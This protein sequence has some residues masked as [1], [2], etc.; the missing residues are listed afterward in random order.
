M[1]KNVLV[2][3]SSSFLTGGGG[4]NFEKHI[5]AVFA[6]ALIIDG[7][8]PISDM[9]V[10]K[11]DFQAKNLGWGTDDLLVTAPETVGGAK[12]LCQMKHSLSATKSDSEFQSVIAEAWKDF[13]NPQFNKNTDRIALITGFI[14]KD[15]IRALREIHAEAIGNTDAQLF[16]NRIALANY[17]SDSTRAVFEA[18]KYAIKKASHDQEPTSE[19]LWGFWRCFVFAIFDL[20]YKDSVNRVLVKSLIKCKTAQDATFVWNSICEACSYWN[21]DGATVCRD[22]IPEEI[23][24][25]FGYTTFSNEQVNLTMQMLP[26]KMWSIVAL[27]GSWDENNEADCNSIAQIADISY[28]EFQ[29]ECHNLHLKYPDVLDLKNG[30]WK[31]ND[32]RQV[33]SIVSGFYFDDVIKRAFETAKR[34]TKEKNRQFD[35]DGNYSLL[36]PSNGRFTNSERFRKGLIEGLC[37]LANS[38]SLTNCSDNLLRTESHSLI[39]NIFSDAD[40]LRLSSLSALILPIAEMN[41]S[42]YLNCLE[43]FVFS[44]P[45]EIEKLFPTHEDSP[46]GNPNWISNILFSLERLAWDENYLVQSIRCLGALESLNYE[47]TNWVNAPINTIVNILLPFMP[48]TFASIDKQKNA[49]Q[50]LRVDNR[51]V[52][53]TVVLKLLPDTSS[54]VVTGTSKPKYIAMPATENCEF[55]QQQRF[56]LFQYYTQQAL[57]IAGTNATKLLPLIK[58]T[59]YMS[60]QEIMD[61]LERICTSCGLWSDNEKCS[62]WIELEDL[63]YRGVHEN[64]E[65]SVDSA[66]YTRLCDTITAVTPRSALYRYK[67]LYVSR[68]Y[69][70]SLGENRWDKL[71]EERQSA[72]EEIYRSFGFSGAVEFGF[73]VNAL[74]EIG[75][76]IGKVLSAQEINDVIP[77]FLSESV[78]AFYSYLIR[79]FLDENGVSA[80]KALNLSAYKKSDIVRILCLAPFTQAL[81]E[82][83]PEFLGEEVSLYWSSVDIPSFYMRHA[84][85][86]ISLVAKTLI[87]HQRASVAVE[88]FADSIHKR[89]HAADL[90]IEALVQ[91]ASEKGV[92]S[93]QYE[94]QQLILYLQ[95]LDHP[96]IDTLSDVEFLYL[97]WLDESSEAKPKAIKYRLA[98]EPPY[99]CNIIELAYKRRN[100]PSKPKGLPEGMAKRLFEIT[101]RYDVIPGT[102]WTG[103]FHS[104]IFDEWIAKVKAWA[105]END[106][107]EVS[108]QLIGNG[109]SYAKFDEN[110][111]LASSIMTV[112]NA[113]DNDEIRNGYRFG[114]MNQRGI[115]WLD[116]EGREERALA[117][118]FEIRADSI[119]KLGYSR[120]A[121][122]LRSISEQYIKEAEDNAKLEFEDE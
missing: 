99:F 88:L 17:H 101:Y 119:E 96:D 12:L 116:P 18:V 6:L 46:I 21:Q 27:I 25:L 47:K 33:L 42:V 14:A 113:R 28:R 53:W 107:F 62:F 70:L 87:E 104:D 1:A 4:M 45:T 3:T 37:M 59:S 9:P 108:M 86:D 13:N 34:F 44:K 58:R 82:M 24:S 23:L 75:R 90:I 121:E 52:C 89:K 94:V 106:R 49:F 16:V 117:K 72:V 65:A 92:N 40:W 71:E 118:Q 84:D 35:S 57:E 36:I 50:A 73:S 93:R 51:D 114:I 83:L 103:N 79:S 109:L 111:T 48:Q 77:Q 8:A 32:R 5:Q 10:Q 60:K 67:R 2:P 54:S 85:Y 100:N 30:K 81:L 22:N 98:N 29:E 41:P 80:I 19:Q 7:F 95:N 15:S 110:N 26:N 31:V 39:S 66:L 20:D 55:S 105:L 78:P 38:T 97:L 11:L 115:H 69:S 91:A 61:L 102:D 122:T 63:H 64:D 68:T 76:R 74:P 43:K 112:L 120:F 56:S